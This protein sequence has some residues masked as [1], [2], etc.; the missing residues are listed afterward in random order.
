M[1]DL[2]TPTNVIFASAIDLNP[3]FYLFGGLLFD[4]GVCW[5]RSLD[6]D[7]GLTLDNNNP[8]GPVHLHL[9]PFYSAASDNSVSNVM[10]NALF[11]LH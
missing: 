5:V 11:A 7:Q 8:P 6:L 3:S 1:F 10:F 9:W 4:L 2:H